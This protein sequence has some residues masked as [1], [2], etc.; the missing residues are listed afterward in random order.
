MQSLTK[1]LPAHLLWIGPSSILDPVMENHDLMLI[2]LHHKDVDNNNNDNDNND[3]AD[4]NN[5]KLKIF[6]IGTSYRYVDLK[7]E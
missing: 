1:T 2:V 4:D 7:S 6:S 3:D 5:N